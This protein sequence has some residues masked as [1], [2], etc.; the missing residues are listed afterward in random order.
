M[1]FNL[2][3]LQHVNRYYFTHLPYQFVFHISFVFVIL[4]THSFLFLNTMI[5]IK[6]SDNY[7]SKVTILYCLIHSQQGN[8]TNSLQK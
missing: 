8:R 3:V 7:I 5:C 1:K 6:R 4:Q 2:V